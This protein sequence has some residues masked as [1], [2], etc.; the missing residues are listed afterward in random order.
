MTNRISWKIF[1]V[2]L[3]D[4]YNSGEKSV[5]C[6]TLFY[7]QLKCDLRSIF[8]SSQ[9]FGTK[10][11][12]HATFFYVLSPC[13]YNW[14]TVWKKI[15]SLAMYIAVVVCDWP[16]CFSVDNQ[17][18]HSSTYFWYILEGANHEFTY[19]QTWSSQTLLCWNMPTVF[20]EISTVCKKLLVGKGSP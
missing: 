4:A 7:H 1:F 18:Q 12:A 2:N 3:N 14:F 19:S 13:T 16:I 11:L 8:R 10:V 6:T 9:I 20:S 5:K 17:L 15:K